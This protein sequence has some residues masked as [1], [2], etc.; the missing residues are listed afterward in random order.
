MP[1]LIGIDL[2]TTFSAIATVDETGR[3]IIVH[4]GEG[5]NVTP[6]CVQFCENDVVEVGEIPRKSLFLAGS[7]AVGRFKRDMGTSV[8]YEARGQ[9]YSPTDLSTFVLKKLR[10]E[11]SAALGEIAQAVV[12]IPANFSNDAREATMAAARAAGLD[13]KYIINEPTAA[14][15]YYAFKGGTDVGGVHAVY[16]LGGGTF[17][18]SLVRVSGRDIEVLSTNGVARLGGD[19]FDGA[20]QALVQS[21]FAEQTGE[22][23]DERDFTKNDAESEKR[24][25]SKRDKVTVRVSRTTIELTRSEFEE[26][27]SSYLAQTEMMCEA[28]VRDAGLDLTDIQGVFL[29]GGSTRIPAVRESV[30]RSFDR[31][32]IATANVDEV[33]ALG[34]ALYAAFKGDRSHLNEVQKAAID[35]IK[36]SESTSQC[37]GT[38]SLSHDVERDQSR[39]VNSVLI[40]K[41]HK[42]PCFVTESFYTVHDDQTSVHCRVTESAAAESDPRFVR[43]VWEGN[44]ELPPGRPAGQEI[45]VTFAYDE[46]QVMNCS[47]V[48]RATGQEE[49][50]D[51]ALNE[52]TQSSALIDRFVVE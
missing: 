36:V 45:L 7:H 15:L 8:Q 51:L 1:A 12:T 52:G 9:Q 26:S 48:D 19:D 25:L 42:I 29:V 46:N 33:V 38:I 17:D 32:P 14:A 34:A 44:L 3:P 41:G 22:T 5:S 24:S 31:D 50:V 21:K 49:K 30:R 20:L 27:I 16:D 4:N 23:L 39:P 47:F 13:V 28:T 18:V 37:Y 43:T 2:G 6:S 10:Q 35:S 11:A 40:K